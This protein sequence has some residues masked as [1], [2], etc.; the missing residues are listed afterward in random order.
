MIEDDEV[1]SKQYVCP[2]CGDKASFG[3][4]FC[5]GKKKKNTKK[6]NLSI[7]LQ[8]TDLLIIVGV[9]LASVLSFRFYRGKALL[10]ISV[11]PLYFII[12]TIFKKID[13]WNKSANYREL[14]SLVG[15][16]GLTVERLIEI[17]KKH[18]NKLSRDECIQAAKETLL[19]DRKR[20]F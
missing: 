11:L 14:L 8:K 4:H 13:A 1:F 9:L 5:T 20:K 7:L 15:F 19:R 18:N 2:Y 6:N 10:I 16:D 12:K 17:E 3:E